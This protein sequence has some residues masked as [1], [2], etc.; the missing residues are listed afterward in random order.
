MEI[1]LAQSFCNIAIFFSCEHKKFVTNSFDRTSKTSN[2]HRYNST[3]TE[4]KIVIISNEI[5][6]QI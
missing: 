3:K 1:L 5:L 4:I 2:S 6:C